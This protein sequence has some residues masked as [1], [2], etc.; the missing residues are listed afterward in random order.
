M[1]GAAA[2][3]YAI[4]HAS[5]WPR[6]ADDCRQAH[7]ELV[8]RLPEQ[9]F[10]RDTIF[11]TGETRIDNPP[12]GINEEQT[13]PGRYYFDCTEDASGKRYLFRV[14]L[15]FGDRAAVWAEYIANQLPNSEVVD[16]A[17]D[18]VGLQVSW[19]ETAAI[20]AFDEF[21]IKSAPRF[22]GHLDISGN[23]IYD[24]DEVVLTSGQT[25]ASALQYAGIARPGN[26]VR[27]PEC[28]AGLVPQVV[29]L[30]LEI[31]HED[32]QALT[33][34]RTY[35]ADGGS[36][37]QIKSRIHGVESESVDAAPVRVSVFTLCS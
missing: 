21:V 24:A 4:A 3:S 2:Q 22:E 28:P 37:W 19:P 35:A 30:P 9:A 36:R 23:S 32:L 5:Q 12:F 16:G 17:Q 10:G 29:T 1:L 31:G 8:D 27:K 20:P 11:Y 14:R 26:Y 18:I 6:Q 34:F 25:L 33:Y 15:L 7:L 13:Y